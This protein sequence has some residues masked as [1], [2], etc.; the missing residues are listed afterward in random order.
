MRCR[1]ARRGISLRMI[2]ARLAEIMFD[3]LGRIHEQLSI[4]SA[5]QCSG[6]ASGVGPHANQLYMGNP[7]IPRVVLCTCSRII[8]SLRS[9]VSSTRI[10]WWISSNLLS[11]DLTQK[12]LRALFAWVIE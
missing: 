9:L 12:S 7:S 11:E 10:S 5:V 6:D 2:R 1:V 3:R 4:P 8:P